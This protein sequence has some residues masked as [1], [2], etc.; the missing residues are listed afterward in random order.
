MF[1]DVWY[2]KDFGASCFGKQEISINTITETHMYLKTIQKDS[3]EDAFVY[4][5]GEVWSPNGEAREL[6]REKGLHHTSMS[7]GD[8]I[9]DIEGDL[10]YKCLD[11]GWEILK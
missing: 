6:I 7:V 1:L 4:M 5:Q 3:L 2:S 11:L 10:W 9:H 8:V